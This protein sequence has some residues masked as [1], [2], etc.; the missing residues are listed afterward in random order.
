M[1]NIFILEDNLKTLD[2]LSRL[3]KD[4]RPL[5]KIFS[6]SDIESAKIALKSTK[7]FNLFFLD[8]SLESNLSDNFG[9][10]FAR[11][12][13]EMPQYS[14]TPIIFITGYDCPLPEAINNIHCFRFLKK[15]VFDTELLKAYD[16]A[17]AKSLVHNEKIT[18]RLSSGQLTFI[19]LTDI[20]YISSENHNQ[21][22]HTSNGTLSGVRS[23]LV[24]IYNTFGGKLVFCSRNTLINPEHVSRINFYNNTVLIRNETLKIGAPYKNKLKE[25]FS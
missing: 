19:N 5:V 11:L 13:R 2:F 10:V 15:P 7:I 22:Y 4:N 20:Y 24:N 3:I 12:I 9:Y 18:I 16:D 14:D 23:S 8:I 25:I 21:Y 6:F 1:N 17:M